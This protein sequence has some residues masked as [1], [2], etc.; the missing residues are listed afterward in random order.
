MPNEL[1]ISTEPACHITVSGEVDA[2]TAPQ[3]NAAIPLSG[4]VWID[5]SGVT[6]LD[7][8][9][10]SVLVEASSAARNRGNR[11]HVSGLRGGPLRVVQMTHLWETLC[12]E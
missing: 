1:T 10:L 11:L 12:A 8:T 3:L 4:W 5:F 9:G 7:S 2:G 6:F